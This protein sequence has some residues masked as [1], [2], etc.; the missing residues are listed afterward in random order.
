LL[1]Q[2][3]EGNSPVWG[4]KVKTPPDGWVVT[5]E[6]DFS[7]ENSNQWEMPRMR[8]REDWF[9]TQFT[10]GAYRWE[11]DHSTGEFF[12]CDLPLASSEVEDMFQVVEFEQLAPERTGFY[13][14]IA[15][16]SVLTYHKMAFVVYDMGV[17]DILQINGS[18]PTSLIGEP[19]ISDAIQKTG[20]NKL[21]VL[22][23]EGNLRFYINDEQVGHQRDF[24]A[25]P[26]KTGIC[27]GTYLDLKDATVSVH[28]FKVYAPTE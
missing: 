14:G 17:F 5:F 27:I 13:Y 18:N 12:K 21:A 7:S 6:E 9:L 2:D 3:S 15:F 1:G 16:Q 20:I 26:G 23:Q 10:D 8:G 4:N 19:R 28:S 24:A 22:I 25:Q 11:F